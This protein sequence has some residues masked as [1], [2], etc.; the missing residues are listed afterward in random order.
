MKSILHKTY[1]KKY[2]TAIPRF[3]DSPC[4]WKVI[5]Y[6]DVLLML[7]EALNE[8]NK[9][10]EALMYVNKVRIRA[11]VSPYPNNISKDALREEIYDERRRELSFEG[12]RW[13]DLARTGRVLKACGLEDRPYMVLFPIPLSQVQVM[14]NSDIFPQNPGWD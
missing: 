6:A 1:T 14:N 7:A 4:N 13:W 2:L 8:N 9:T 11:N 12:H 3:N 10:A 5:R